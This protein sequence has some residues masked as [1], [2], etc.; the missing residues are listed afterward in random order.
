MPVQSHWRHRMTES[1]YILFG[2]PLRMTPLTHCTDALE[3]NRKGI[4][5]ISPTLW[6][7]LVFCVFFFMFPLFPSS[8]QFRISRFAFSFV[9]NDIGLGIH[10]TN[11][12]NE[13]VT[14]QRVSKDMIKCLNIWISKWVNWSTRIVHT[15]APIT[16]LLCQRSAINKMSQRTRSVYANFAMRFHLFSQ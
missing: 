4:T 5:A 16:V 8:P 6:I 10:H 2:H 3:L 13:T 7:R 15:S 1:F 14:T 9:P 12:R 11:K